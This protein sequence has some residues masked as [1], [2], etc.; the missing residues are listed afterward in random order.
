MEKKIWV[1]LIYKGNDFGGIFE[2]SEDGEIR[3]KSTRNILKAFWENR[4]MYTIISYNNR[5][6]RIVVGVA[7]KESRLVRTVMDKPRKETYEIKDVP[8][9]TEEQVNEIIKIVRGEINNGIKK[10]E[11][12]DLSRR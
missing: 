9:F 7:Q 6:Y 2:I 4:K 5:T 10:M 11:R 12:T 8:T 3:N 1:T